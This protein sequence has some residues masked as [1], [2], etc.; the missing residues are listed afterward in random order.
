MQLNSRQVTFWGLLTALAVVLT[1]FAS[2]RIA[3]G[4][5]EGIRLGFGALPI[6]MAGVYFGPLG[7]A[8]VGA[9]A[10][11]VGFFLSPIGVYM[12]HFTV[13]SALTGALPGLVW[14]RYADR[15]GLPKVSELILYVG[16][17]Q[18]ITS[19]F[20][21]PYFLEVLFGIPLAITIIPRLVAQII[22]IPI[23]SF[24]LRLLLDRLVQIGVFSYWDNNT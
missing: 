8:V 2:I 24:I 22:Q 5:V 3:I 18:I 6:I 16:G 15:E 17:T 12:P 4:G 7:G 20:M 14:Y 10:D 11:V 21:V 19:V 1:R 13:T 9:I 23:Y